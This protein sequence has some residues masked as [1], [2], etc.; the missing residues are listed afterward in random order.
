MTAYKIKHLRPTVADINLTAL[1]KNFETLKKRINEKSLTMIVVKADAYGHGLVQIS[2]EVIKLGADRLGVATVEEGVK[3]RKAGIT[4]PIHLLGSFPFNQVEEV[5][6]NN[7]IASVSD[8]ILAMEINNQSKKL[9]KKTKVHLK[10][11]SGLNRFGINP[12]NTLSFCENYYS[13]PHLVWEGIYTHFSQA[14]SRDWSTTDEQFYQFKTLVNKLEANG[15]CFPVKHVAN[16]TLIIENPEYHLDMVRLG[17]ALYGAYPNKNQENLIQLYPVMNIT[18]SIISIRE[19]NK[20]NFVGYG[21][22][23]FTG[24]KCKKIAIIPIGSADGYKSILSK[25]GR[26]IVNDR[27]VR[28][29]GGISL[30]FTMIDVTGINNVHLNQK[31][32]LLGASK[33]KFITINDMALWANLIPDEIFISISQRVRKEYTRPPM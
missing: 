20:N 12:K 2:R 4:H 26:I 15:F 13:L 7:L 3:L 27:L 22:E 1:Y 8:E 16:S 11:N 5:V 17:V 21:K 25:D 24:E 10:I 19:V 31:V 30:D 23:Y 33:N 32:T 9:N 6:L 14:D 18:S 29:F 28:I